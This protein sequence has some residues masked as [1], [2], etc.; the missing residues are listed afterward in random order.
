MRFVEPIADAEDFGAEIAAIE[1][2]LPGRCVTNEELAALH[3]SWNMQQVEPRTGVQKRHWCSENE[4]SLD[5]AEAA[6]RKL[7]AR[8]DLSRVSV[9]LFCT[10]TPDYAMPPN[11]GLL[12]HRLGLP[13]SIAALD[14]SLACSGFVYGLYLADALIRSKSAEHV[15]LIT[16]ETYS[17]I[18]NSDDRGPASLFGDGA[19]ATLIRRGSRD[20]GPF[21]NGTDGGAAECF[22]IP[23]GGARV[24]RSDVTGQMISDSFGN[25]RSA[26][27]IHMN[28]ANVLDYFKREVPLAVNCLLRRAKIT[29]SEVDLV[30]P[31]QASAIALELIFKALKVLPEKRYSNLERTGNTVSASIPIALRDAEVEGVL[32]SGMLILL[33]GFGV[34]LSWSACLLRWR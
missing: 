15:L 34:G 23:A 6:C 8:A 9:L 18:M 14:Y 26:E 21:V 29:I 19:A 16:A 27:Q 20:I 2:E 22:I 25:I 1:Y 5:L 17:K 33:I 24:P 32:E 30:V 12:Q 3:P 31:H 28:G 11:A 13:R 7:A 4:T 10:Q